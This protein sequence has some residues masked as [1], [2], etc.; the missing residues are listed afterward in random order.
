MALSCLST[1]LLLGLLGSAASFAT[2]NS[3]TTRQLSTT[4]TFLFNLGAASGSTAKI[5]SSP[6]DRD[7]AAIAAVKAA[8]QKPR[9]PSCPLIECEFPALTA[10]NKLGDGSLRSSLEAEDANAAFVNKLVSG[11]ATPFFGPS[12]SIVMSSSASNALIKKVQKKVKGATVISAKEGM[13][14]EVLKKDNVCIFLTPSSQKD[15]QAA[16]TLAEYGCP[17]VLVNGSFKD[18]K[19]IPGSATMAFFYKPLTYNS[20][21][22]GFLIR[23]YPSLWTVLDAQSK[24]VLGS[25]TDEQ[26]LVERTNTPD[27]R[28]SVRLV[29]KFVDERAI[30]ARAK[31]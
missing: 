26:I 1:L 31:M 27:L 18:L 23:S 14:P 17:A 19:S 2:S 20:A 10:L 24:S 30:K 12:V 6:N 22:A 29:Q 8:I 7:K 15:Y 28:A 9:N 5:P 3:R 25:F 16:R 11:I 13:P 4:Q 21:V